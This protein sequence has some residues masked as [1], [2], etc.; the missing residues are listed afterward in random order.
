MYSHWP[1]SQVAWWKS[2]QILLLCQHHKTVMFYWDT[3]SSWN[4]KLRKG[5]SQ[6]GIWN[7]N[8]GKT[9]VVFTTSTPKERAAVEGRPPLK[10]PVGICLKGQS[11]H[12]DMLKSL[13][14][15]YFCSAPF[16]KKVTGRLW[17]SPPSFFFAFFMQNS[18][19][20]KIRLM[21]M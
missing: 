19:F 17:V 18:S 7:L 2:L 12:P 5:E 20:T 8:V 10:C 1:T 14:T 13:T 11:L 15:F 4:S 16:G 3:A 6:N 21:C 9:T